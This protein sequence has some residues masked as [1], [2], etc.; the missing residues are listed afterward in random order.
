MLTLFRKY[1]KII[2]IFTTGVIIISFTFFGAM[3]SMGGAPEVKEEIV[4]KAVDGTSITSQ[5]IERMVTFLSSSQMDLKDDQIGTVNLLNDGVLE[6][7]FL[8]VGLGKLLAEQVVTE[9]EKDLDKSIEKASHFQGY[10]HSFA[11]FI[12]SESIWLQ[13]APESE[14]IAESLT[15]RASSLSSLKKFELLSQA[16]LQHQMVPSNFIRKVIAYQ[17]QQ[18][19]QSE[20]DPALPYADVSLLGLHSAKDF[21]GENYIR[22]A[23][24]VVINGAAYARKRG[25]KVSSQEARESL[26]A[27]AKQ[28]AQM[29]SQDLSAETNFYQIFLSQARNLGM[30]E[31]ECIDLWKDITLF[32]KIFQEATDAIVVNPENLPE[33]KEQALVEK[34]SLP[35]QLQFKDFNSFMKL[36]VYINAVS[37]K[38]RTKENLLLLPTEILSLEE[39]E[40]K[41]PDLVEKDYVLEYSEV[42]S[43]KIAS[44]IGLKETWGWQTQDDGWRVL[45]NQFAKQIN[46]SAKTK[47]ERFAALEA[48]PLKQRAEID[49]FSR[50]QILAK[51]HKRIQNDLEL[52]EPEIK[53][54][55]LSPSG[56]EL[57][58]KGITDMS[59]LVSLLEN[60]PLKGEGSSASSSEEQLSFFTGDN[61]HYYKI[62]VIERSSVKKVRTFAQAESSGALRRM[63]DKKL[64]SAYLEVRKKDPLPYTKKEG[65]WKALAEVKEKVGFATYSPL[66]KEIVA[67]YKEVYNKEPSKEEIASS[68]FYARNWM[69]SYMQNSLAKVKEE[70]LR[71]LEDP[72]L[73]QW[74]LVQKKE[75]LIKKEHQAI[76]NV[77]FEENTWSSLLSLS[78]GNLCFFKV[79][80]KMDPAPFSD[81]ELEKVTTPLKRESEKK[82]FESLFAEIKEK[83]LI[84]FKAL[85]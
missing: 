8:K 17:A 10:R 40:K 33:P 79:L 64:A 42:D 39:I 69:L 66:L 9:L 82:L 35:S 21:L 29:V 34:Y 41:S 28:A 38:K 45:Q 37:A 20:E 2:F 50:E 3:N 60:A 51:D 49:K 85:V 78:S 32:K 12:T 4:T 47:E 23:S 77:L 84:S 11:S 25:Y 72:L 15:R 67:K 16:Y 31:M 76:Q 5:K 53:S 63:L 46:S 30:T 13:F 71:P 43:K 73:D 62:S 75:A 44:K 6:N 56:F 36:Q 7:S 52:A 19:T 80:Q 27:N 54:I 65:G 83:S 18:M 59:S 24:Q 68:E 81:A 48:L 58:F 26:V 1:Q 70:G 22:A 14:K 74:T 57:P 61:Q 55:A